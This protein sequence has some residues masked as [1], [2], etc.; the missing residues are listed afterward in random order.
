MRRAFHS[1]AA[2]V[3]AAKAAAFVLTHSLSATGSQHHSSLQL[4]LVLA[5]LREEVVDDNY[6]LVLEFAAKLEAEKWQERQAKFQSFFGPGIVARIETTPAGA[7]VYLI[8]DGTGAGRSG[9]EK[10]DVL[11]PLMPGLKAR[12]QD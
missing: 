6:T 5:G 12:Q 10:K 2:H 1:A 3:Q 7:D 8:C 9:K 11:P 4:N